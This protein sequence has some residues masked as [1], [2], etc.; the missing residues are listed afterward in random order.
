[1]KIGLPLPRSRSQL[2]NTIPVVVEEEGARVSLGLWIWLGRG[3]GKGQVD[4]AHEKKDKHWG[5]HF[6][7]AK[8]SNEH[9]RRIFF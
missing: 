8:G 5:P 4:K 6:E 1:M 9:F 3:K 2:L 7:A